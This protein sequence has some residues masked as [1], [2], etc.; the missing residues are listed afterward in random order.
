MEQLT[1]WAILGMWI[2]Q[3]GGA[4]FSVQVVTEPRNRGVQDIL[5]ACVDG[6]K[7][8]PETHEAVFP[9]TS[10]QSHRAHGLAQPELR[11][12]EAAV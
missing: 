1:F 9:Y 7:G 6:L 8:F 2:A 4:E 11:V 12:L 5:V 3:C 10:M